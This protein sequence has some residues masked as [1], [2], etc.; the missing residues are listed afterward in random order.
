MDA[1]VSFLKHSSAL[2]LII[3]LLVILSAVVLIVVG[4]GI[5]I[6]A[7]TRK[8]IYYFLVLTLLPLFLAL[9]GTYLRFKVI[10]R[11][12]ADFPEAS[13][14]IVAAASEEAWITTYI[15]VAA[16]ILPGL[17]GVAGLLFKKEKSQSL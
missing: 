15:G 3:I 14:E 4:I 11:A 17:I 1:L 12:L 2:D 7:K 8:P 16:T 9:L 13:T 6:A 10:D 5:L